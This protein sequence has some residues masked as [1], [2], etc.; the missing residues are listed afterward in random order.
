MRKQ[1][2]MVNMESNSDRLSRM[3]FTKAP[4][5]RLP[6]QYSVLQK[7]NLVLWS[8]KLNQNYAIELSMTTSSSS[9]SISKNLIRYWSNIRGMRICNQCHRFHLD[10]CRFL[11]EL[12]LPLDENESMMKL[13]R[14][15]EKQCPL[16]AIF[17]LANAA[18]Q[19]TSVKTNNK[20]VFGDTRKSLKND[21]AE[22]LVF[23]ENH[24][25]NR[26]NWEK[27]RLCDD[28]PKP[29]NSGCNYRLTCKKQNQ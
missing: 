26:M 15:H 16:L 3:S 12:R 17:V 27:F 28:C 13:W 6:V 11:L 24:L 10:F 4:L 22:A 19:P 29:P 21:R 20:L 2:S 8:K 9:S 1:L 25:P 23:L 18:F 14:D 5:S 7:P